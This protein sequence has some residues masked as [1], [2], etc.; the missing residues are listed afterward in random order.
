MSMMIYQCHCVVY[1]LYKWE[2]IVKGDKMN[3]NA[4]SDSELFDVIGDNISYYRRLYSLEKEKM[5]QER[6]AEIIGVSTSLIGGLESKKTNQGISVP[7]LYRI[8]VALE[9]SI[10]KLVTKRK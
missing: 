3:L 5:T 8:S 7:T 4:M 6:L 1:Y 10:D 2:N 9:I